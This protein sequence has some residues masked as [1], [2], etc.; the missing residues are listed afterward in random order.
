MS[1]YLQKSAHWH[2]WANMGFQDPSLMRVVQTLRIICH[3]IHNRAKTAPSL[4]FYS[5]CSQLLFHWV[6]NTQLSM[7]LY[8]FSY[9]S[10]LSAS[11]G[12]A[13]DIANFRYDNG[14]NLG[15]SNFYS[16]AFTWTFL[17]V[18]SPSRTV[19]FLSI[20]WQWTYGPTLFS[21]NNHYE[22]EPYLSPLYGRHRWDLYF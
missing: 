21:W 10:G 4:H 19:S 3:L 5:K 1:Q 16:D 14:N 18:D 15:Y 11:E 6:I 13:D 9:L 8:L 17:G 22:S 12:Q 20:K 7:K 2:T